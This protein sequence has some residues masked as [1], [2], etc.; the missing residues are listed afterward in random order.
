M[1]FKSIILIFI[2]ITFISCGILWFRK[3]LSSS[4]AY[5]FKEDFKYTFVMY[6]WKYSGHHNPGT[7]RRIIPVMMIIGG[8]GIIA[9]GVIKIF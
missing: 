8:I 6:H 1:W 3:S 9:V 2:S 5:N 4:E 7:H